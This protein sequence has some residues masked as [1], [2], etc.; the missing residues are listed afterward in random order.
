MSSD[1]MAKTNLMNKLLEDLHKY[2]MR[3]GIFQQNMAHKMGVVHTDLKTADILNE[4]GPIT[5][6]ELSKITGLSTGSV[7]AL[8]DRLE[9]AGYV[10]RERDVSD[11]RRVMIVPIPERHKEIMNHYHSLGVKTKKLCEHYEEHELKLILQFVSD[12]TDVLDQENE[13]LTQERDRKES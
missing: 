5:A 9:K 3:T 6:G 12:I 1:K 8:V 4:K 10:R 11:R 7:T 13:I 2:G